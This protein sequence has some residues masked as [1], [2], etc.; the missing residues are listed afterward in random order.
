MLDLQ[1]KRRFALMRRSFA[2][3]GFSSAPRPDGTARADLM[4][5]DTALTP[6]PG[7][8]RHG[9]DW[10]R[11]PRDE[12][13]NGPCEKTR[14]AV[15]RLA[16]GIRRE[17]E[18]L[19]DLA[20]R[21]RAEARRLLRE[22]ADLTA[23]A[24]GLEEADIEAAIDL[25][26]PP[27]A[28]LTSEISATAL[29]VSLAAVRAGA[30]ARGF[31][32]AAQG[33]AD[34]A[35]VLGDTWRQSEAL[36]VALEERS[37]ETATLAAALRRRGTALVE[38]YAESD[39]YGDLDRLGALARTTAETAMRIAGSAED[40]ART[41]RL[42][43]EHMIGLAGRTAELDR[44]G[45]ERVSVDFVCEVATA[46]AHVAGQVRDLSSTGALVALDDDTPFS[47]GQP[48]TIRLRDVPE[49]AGSVVAQDGR[50]LRVSFDLRHGA[51]AAAAPALDRLIREAGR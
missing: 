7:D 37:A 10:R 46:S 38:T 12:G 13:A 18:V 50:A 1:V 22:E 23:A 39:A 16:A 33:I 29:G 41:V 3:L 25:L 17:A 8:Q 31:V 19:E 27:I 42:L 28:A 43:A 6:A 49:I 11:E 40:L 48:L 5:D 26:A 51:N 34:L 20:T 32:S 15:F 30:S 36:V 4:L 9:V 35:D 2:T 14:E 24:A 21:A 44:R 47:A 45:E